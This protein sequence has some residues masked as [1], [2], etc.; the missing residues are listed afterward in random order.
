MYI[1]DKLLEIGKDFENKFF[2]GRNYVLC[3]NP[4]CSDWRSVSL[5]REA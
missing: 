3:L 2:L 5:H 4:F 1:S